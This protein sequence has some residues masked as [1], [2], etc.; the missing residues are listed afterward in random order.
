M[1]VIVGWFDD[2]KLKLCEGRFKY[3]TNQQYG[4][5]LAHEYLL[6]SQDF[7]FVSFIYYKIETEVQQKVELCFRS[8]GPFFQ[9]YLVEVG[10]FTSVRENQIIV[11]RKYFLLLDILVNQ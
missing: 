2:F 3:S 5:G 7:E 9:F 4:P 6:F 1:R 11:K 10:L 8:H